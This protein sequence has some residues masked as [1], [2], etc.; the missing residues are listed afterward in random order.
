MT[1]RRLKAF[2]SL[3][4]I[5]G[6]ITLSFQGL[7]FAATDS[8]VD[9]FERRTFTDLSKYSHSL[10]YRLYIPEN[11]NPQQAYPLVLFLHGSG[12]RGTDN[13]LQLT[14]NKGATVWAEPAVQA[15]YPSFVLA[16]QCPPDERWVDYIDPTLGSYRLEDFPETD[17]IQ[18]VLDIIKQ[19]QNEFTID[20]DRIYSTGLS[21]GSFGTWS[22]NL[23]HPDLFAAAVAVCGAA[24]PTKAE[25][26]ASKPI[27]AFHGDI[28]NR[29]PVQASRDMV[30][31]INALGGNAKY[32]EY[33]G[34]GHESWVPAFNT[35]ELPDWLFSQ[36]LGFSEISA[37]QD[38][39]KKSVKINGYL[40]SAKSKYITIM[41]RDPRGNVDYVDQVNITSN[42]RFSFEFLPKYKVNG[43]YTF[44]LNGEAGTKAFTGD[45]NYTTDT[46][47]DSTAPIWPA[48]SSL[49]A[50]EIEAS[51]LTLT[52][53]AA[54]DDTAVT[55]YRIFKG[56]QLIGKVAGDVNSYTVTGLTPNTE[57]N[58]SVQ[59]GD[60][61]GNWSGNGPV[62]SVTTLEG[63]TEPAD[64]IAPTWPQGSALTASAIAQTGFTLT[65]AA[66]QDN[67]GVTGYRIYKDSQLI[68]TVAG[69]VL[70]YNVTGLTANTQYS[71]KVEAGDMAG[72]WSSSGPSRTITTAAPSTTPGGDNN[73]PSNPSTGQQEVVVNSDG[74]ID[75]TPVIKEKQAIVSI[76]ETEIKKAADLVERDSKGIKVIPIEIKKLEGAENYVQTLPSNVLTT[77]N[78]DEKLLIKTDIATVTV[79]TNLLKSEVSA[80]TNVQLSISKSNVEA[81]SEELKNKIGERPVID[82]NLSLNNSTKSISTAALGITVSLPYTPS[83][84]ELKDSEHIV[85]W[86][87]DGEGKTVALPTGKYNEADGT[88]SFKTTNIGTYGVTFVN[89]SFDDISKQSWAKDS[90]EV[91][92]AKGV[93]NGTTEKTFNPGSSIKRGDF[94]LMLVKAMGLTAE[95]DGN[96]ADVNPNAYYANAVSVAKELGITAGVG[97]NK[98]NPSEYISRQDMMTLIS[99]AMEIEKKVLQEGNDSD[100]GRFADKTAISAYAQQSIA[101]LVKN[102]IVSGDGKNINPKAKASRAET[103]VMIYKIYNK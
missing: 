78:K 36:H 32:T 88:V 73:G 16:P 100:I 53:S 10:P 21:M 28:D 17:E 84:E 52:W 30:A 56:S 37:V 94:I 54:E 18:M 70:S 63:T 41:V 22:E 97:N 19:L 14:A 69:G 68:A 76:T 59:A 66:A 6:I 33:P 48:G 92:A 39:I 93:I 40:N 72:N 12:E 9:S 71:F 25:L 20:A 47:S 95:G 80:N 57:Y 102:G 29:V 5:V 58:F 50:S 64:N 42:G 43:T 38:P 98:F 44:K 82:V 91:L 85:V 87:I 49:L 67:T 46:V 55:E 35:P 23:Y 75:A 86:Y 79:P 8:I 15:K 65:W 89:K 11:Y 3:V 4:I 77:N 99:R 31:A 45:F 83:A 1:T 51:R 101:T 62:K 61:M 103:A 26:I 2:I 60:Y 24:D 74:K 81:L 34:V 13:D 27:W 96:F 7:T 90:I